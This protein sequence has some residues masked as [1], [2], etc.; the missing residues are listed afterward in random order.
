MG[1]VFRRRADTR[2]RA[3]EMMMDA[4]SGEPWS[5]MDIADLTHSLD[6]GHTFAQTASFLCRDEDEVR[7]KSHQLGL[8]EH[9]HNKLERRDVMATNNPVGDNARKGAVKKRSQL[10]TKTMGKKTFTK[11]NKEG[12]QFMAQKKKTRFKGVRKER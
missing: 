6:Y 12:G 3:V 7:Q 9:H 1:G 10:A 4:N 8:V 5:E 2:G 11:R